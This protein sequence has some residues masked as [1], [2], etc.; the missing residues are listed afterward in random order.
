MPQI[1]PK[2]LNPIARA[3]VLGLPLIAGSTGV[4]LAAFFRSSY[5][6]VVVVKTT[7]L[8]SFI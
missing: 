4:G 6:T 2:A 5:A 8:F 7:L 3:V 1:F